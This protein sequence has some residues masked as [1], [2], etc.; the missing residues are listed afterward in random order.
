MSKLPRCCSCEKCN[1]FKMV[2]TLYPRKIP[3]EIANETIKC[4]SYIPEKIINDK[5]DDDL[6]L[7]KGR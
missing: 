2:C 6:P 1:E 7:A 4:D 3:K 5:S